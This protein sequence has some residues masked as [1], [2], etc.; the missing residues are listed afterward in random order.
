MDVTNTAIAYVDRRHATGV[1]ALRA[2]VRA[3]VRAWVCVRVCVCVCVRAR[4]RA[5]KCVYVLLRCFILVN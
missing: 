2:C 4:A 1:S 5:R 3:C